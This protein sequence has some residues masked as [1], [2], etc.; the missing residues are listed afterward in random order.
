M[1]ILSSSLAE[2]TK[3]AR[4]SCGDDLADGLHNVEDYNIPN[5]CC[6]SFR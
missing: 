2:V 4:M 1:R 5:R 3:D 6:E